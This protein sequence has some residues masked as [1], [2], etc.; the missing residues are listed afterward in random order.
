[1]QEPATRKLIDIKATTFKALSLKAHN[2]GISLKRYI[3]DLLEEEASTDL[4]PAPWGV[5]DKKILSLIGVAKP[6][7][8]S[9][10][11]VDERLEYI[12]SK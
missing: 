12:L 2:K 8:R 7:I 3:E 5:T 11:I 9:E 10:N 6:A 1:M 4:K